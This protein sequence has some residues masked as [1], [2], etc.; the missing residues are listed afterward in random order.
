MSHITINV[1]VSLGTTLAVVSSWQR[2]RSILWAMLHGLL[3]WAYVI[4]FALTRTEAERRLTGK[5]TRSGRA[6]RAAQSKEP[7]GPSFRE[8]IEADPIAKH[9]DSAEQMRRF[10]D[11]RERQRD[12][13]RA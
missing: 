11:W 8:F 7:A 10:A 4:Y 1:G 5:S 12:K 3:S 9:L 6:M 2:N 13:A